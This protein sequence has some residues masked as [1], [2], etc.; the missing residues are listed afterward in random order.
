MIFVSLPDSVQAYHI[1]TQSMMICP[2]SLTA[3]DVIYDSISHVPETSCMFTCIYLHDVSIY[4]CPRTS[5]SIES[6]I[7][8]QLVWQ[9]H[10][11]WIRAG[12]S[13]LRRWLCQPER[14]FQHGC[15]YGSGQFGN[16]GSCWWCMVESTGLLL[17]ARFVC[18]EPLVH[19]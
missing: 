1:C 13:L 4:R 3:T 12:R 5:G 2:T 18:F 10:S 7:L 16:L 19:S 6:G 15:T 11:L 14:S 9:H 8:Q 17:R